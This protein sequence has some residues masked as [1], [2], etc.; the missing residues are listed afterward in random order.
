MVPPQRGPLLNVSGNRNTSDIAVALEIKRQP[1]SIYTQLNCLNNWIR[2]VHVK[3][4]NMLL[5]K[6]CEQAKHEELQ[7]A[8]DVDLSIVAGNIGF[9]KSSSIKLAPKSYASKIFFN[10]LCQSF[11]Q[12][13]VSKLSHPRSKYELFLKLRSDENFNFPQYLSKIHYIYLRKC[14]TK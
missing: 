5:L 13:C 11:F 10:N 14:L 8:T 9:L 6:S 12:K 7:W 4:C 3:A 1:M 2:V